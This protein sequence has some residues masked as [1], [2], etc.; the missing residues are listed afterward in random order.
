MA[1][2]A[3][4]F[5]RGAG[6]WTV[7]ELW[8]GYEEAAPAGSVDPELLIPRLERSGWYVST[9]ADAR[10]TLAPEDGMDA[11]GLERLEAWELANGWGWAE[12]ARELALG[13]AAAAVRARLGSEGRVRDEED[14]LVRGG[15][16]ADGPLLAAAPDR[17][18]AARAMARELLRASESEPRPLGRTAA[19]GVVLAQ[20]VL[21]LGQ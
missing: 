4:V 16:R 6:R 3:I 7:R 21:E 13:D 15:S 8:M 12:A 2:R 14:E 9:R 5:E 20:L 19:R 11:P 10:I 18:V 1:D 17:L